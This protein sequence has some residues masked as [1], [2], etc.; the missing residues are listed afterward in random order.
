MASPPGARHWLVKSE[1]EVYS[2]DDLARDGVTCW[3]GVRNYQARNFL[4][5][6]RVGDA[7][8]FYHS[9]SD[10]VG[11]VGVAAVVRE[12]Y[13]DASQFDP[14]S[15]YF[16]AKSDPASPRW[17]AV[18]VRF[19]RRLARVVPLAEIKADAA[20]AGMLLVQRGQRLSVQPVARH[21]FDAVLRMAGVDP[22]RL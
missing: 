16:D 9:N 14:T 13:A 12:A 15:A 6:M 17:D 8:L 5:D 20:L 19:V 11:V 10:P 7:V 2:I 18:D 4:R 21:E 22:Q 3:D 1:P